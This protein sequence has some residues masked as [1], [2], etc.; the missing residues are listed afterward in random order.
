[1]AQKGPKWQKGPDSFSGKQFS[2]QN[3]KK[4]ALLKWILSSGW[5]DTACNTHAN[6]KLKNIVNNLKMTYLHFITSKLDS[7]N[8]QDEG[9]DVTFQMHSIAKIFD[10]VEYLKN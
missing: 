10:I 9:P 8:G 2:K 3:K 7:K 5:K 6:K 4:W 1:M